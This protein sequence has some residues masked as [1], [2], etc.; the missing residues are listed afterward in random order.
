MPQTLARVATELLNDP[1]LSS[2]TKKSYEGVLTPFVA[3]LGRHFIDKVQ[4]AQIEAYLQLLT[5]INFRT[6]NRHH[7]IIKRLFSF[8]AERDYLTHNPAAHIKRKKPLLSEGEH[9]SD[10]LVRYLKKQELSA[11]YKRS[12]RNL[13]LHALITLL[14]ESGARVAEVLA[15]NTAAINFKNCEFQVVGKGNKKRWCYFGEASTAALQAYFLK[16]DGTHEALFSER[17][18]KSARVRRLSYATAYRE[19]KEITESHPTL[20]TTGFHNLRHTFATERAK[21]VPL[22]V[23]RALLGHENIQTTLIYQKITSEVAR[24]EA[25]KALEAVKQLR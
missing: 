11:L 9:G 5:G 4:R 3:Q 21:V 23:L 22:E 16:K 19:W 2:L 12:A 8:A 7:T 10:E 17:L 14:H 18:V 24:E 25:H 13:R 6:H 1:N 20:R 15:L